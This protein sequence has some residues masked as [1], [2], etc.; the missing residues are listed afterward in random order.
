MNVFLV[1]NFYRSKLI[2]GIIHIMIVCHIQYMRD[3]LWK[4]EEGPSCY[5]FLV[6]VLWCLKRRNCFKMVKTAHIVL[7]FQQIKVILRVIHCFL[8]NHNIW[9]IIICKNMEI[10][11][12]V[13]FSLQDFCN[14]NY[15]NFWKIVK[16][17]H[18][19]EN[20]KHSSFQKT[21]SY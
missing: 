3:N 16:I 9:A 2:S 4:H 10:Y 5:F 21:L 14:V 1:A 19:I 7:N 8:V 12:V 15:Q 20:H 6:D 18:I 13:N 17:G 11:P